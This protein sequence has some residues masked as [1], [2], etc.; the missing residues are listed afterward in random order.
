MKDQLWCRV[1]TYLT[2][3]KRTL[4]SDSMKKLPLPTLEELVKLHPENFR[5]GLNKFSAEE[6]R[7]ILRPE[8]FRAAPEHVREIILKQVRFVDSLYDD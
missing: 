7:Q 1:T 3:P 6:K 2:P 4:P 5:E 8:N